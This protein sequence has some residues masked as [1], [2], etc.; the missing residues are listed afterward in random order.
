MYLDIHQFLVARIRVVIPWSLAHHHLSDSEIC[1][2]DR[3]IAVSK[4]E[5]EMPVMLEGI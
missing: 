3:E 4:Y 1:R 2:P 5:S